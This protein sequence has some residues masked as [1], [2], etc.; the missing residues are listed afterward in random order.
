VTT[1]LGGVPGCWK[2]TSGSWFDVK[3][4]DPKHYCSMSA[5]RQASTQLDTL[6]ACLA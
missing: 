1:T 4:I 5:L 2:L 3:S 6:W